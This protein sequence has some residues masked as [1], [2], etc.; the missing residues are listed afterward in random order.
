MH[1][2][3][4]CPRFRREFIQ[5]RQVSRYNYQVPECF[6][7]NCLGVAI[8]ICAVVDDVDLRYSALGS[9]VVLVTLTNLE[10]ETL[11]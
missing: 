2:L 10:G 7:F 11:V 5:E 9:L 6:A 4:C 8:S 1:W 3:A